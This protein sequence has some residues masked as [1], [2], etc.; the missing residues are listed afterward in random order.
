MVHYF[1][2]HW[3]RPFIPLILQY[4]K[5]CITG[6]AANAIA[7][8]CDL[9]PMALVGAVV[10]AISD[11]ASSNTTFVLYG[12][13]VCMS[14]GGLAIF[15]SYS[16]YVLARMA[17]HIRHDM[18]TKLFQHIQSLDVDFFLHRPKGDILSVLTND[19]DTLNT[20]F[21]ETI[22]NSIRIV[23]AFLGT[24]GYLFWLDWRLGMLLLPPLPMAW[25]AI[26]VFSKRVQPHYIQSRRSI[27]NFSGILENSLQGI[28]TLQ[29]Y[30]AERHE[31]RRINT[32]SAEYRDTAINA[33]RV[34]RNFIPL[35]Y[36]IAGLSFGSLIGIGGWLTLQSPEPN[37][38]AYTTA[39]LMGTR[40]VIPIFAL[41]FLV[42]QVQRAK[43]AFSRVR[44][45][46][47]T[48][49]SIRDEKNA[50]PLEY[51]IKTISF[52]D[53]AYDYPAGQRGVR[54][55][56]FELKEGQFIGIAG[57]TGAGKSTLLKLLL[58][59]CEPSAGTIRINGKPLNS[60]TLASVRQQ[61]GYVSQQPFLFRGTLRENFCLG[62][63]EATQ[64]QLDV[65][66][67]QAGL[68]D[69]VAALPEGYDTILG[70][71]GGTLSGG[72]KQRVALA[73]ALLHTPKVFI[74]DEATSAIDTVTEQAIQQNILKLRDKSLIIAV[75]HRLTTLTECDSI[76][77]M[78]KGRI[79]EQGNHADLLAQ[80]GV[81]A[82]LWAAGMDA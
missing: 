23:M 46:L 75:A 70:D 25:V 82:N 1:F 72:Q 38:G 59:F 28:D 62:T 32:L 63:P 58:R 47:D 8:V 65:A 17:H 81:Y 55:L 2:P 6:V 21:S 54:Q 33:A 48:S 14:F 15:Q 77:V 13:A 29:A 35:I 50:S 69:M 34:R 24:Y 7:R 26:T 30:C 3:L 60:C 56:A 42:N 27:G 41:G 71:G 67:E 79:V 16:E 12:V 80:G 45:L 10:N 57:A 43:A 37:I 73:R 18:R 5:S 11:P 44:E 74:L 19:I 51:P 78:E 61:V 66:V 22:A 64:E 40:L 52:A 9:L 36:L 76:L 53:V 49:P 20:F 68:A 31:M 39:V 4:K